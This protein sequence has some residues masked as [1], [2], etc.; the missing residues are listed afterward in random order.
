MD[1]T[2]LRDRIQSTLDPNTSARQQ[3]EL[4]LKYV[5]LLRVPGGRAVAVR[6]TPRLP[7]SRPRRSPDL[8]MRC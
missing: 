4:D 7:L 1:V 2:A 8:S 3:A 6:L 5:R